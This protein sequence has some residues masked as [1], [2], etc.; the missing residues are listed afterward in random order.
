MPKVLGVGM[1]KTGTTTLAHAL[2]ILGY[3]PHQTYDLKA[4]QK[5]ASGKT[6]ELLDLYEDKIVFEDFPWPLMYREFYSR[7]P[8]AHF[9]LTTR[10][11]EEAWFNSLVKHAERTGPTEM[12]KLV[13]GHE[14]PL[15]DREKHLAVYR[16]HNQEVRSF[17]EAKPEAQFIEVCWEEGHGWPEL[18]TFL[19]QPVPE[20]PFPHM[21][22]KPSLLRKWAKRLF[23]GKS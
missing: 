9:I 23:Y 5:W 8:D 14:M 7:Y 10:R 1:N 18:C 20:Q 19:E 3:A 11:S 22:A 12:R 15:E 2:R 13:Y 17:F 21:N 4:T 16:N 6:E